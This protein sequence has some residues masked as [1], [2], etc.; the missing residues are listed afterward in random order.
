M[1]KQKRKSDFASVLEDFKN[2]FHFSNEFLV[3]IPR[4]KNYLFDLC[5]LYMIRNQLT[6]L[7]RQQN[8]NY[9]LKVIL[10]VLLIVIAIL[11]INK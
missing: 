2:H 5:E 7:R 3:D 8:I 11:I 4:Y 9:R 6:E 1:K 10:Y